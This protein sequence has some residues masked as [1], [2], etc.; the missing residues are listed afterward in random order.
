M[1]LLILKILALLFCDDPAPAI[2]IH[3]KG[4]KA[5][6]ILPDPPPNVLDRLYPPIVMPPII[7]PQS[8]TDTDP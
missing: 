5:A 8:V 3:E 7:N 1:K 2:E 4:A 6:L